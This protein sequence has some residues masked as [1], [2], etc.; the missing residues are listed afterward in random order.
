MGSPCAQSYYSRH[1]DSFNMDVNLLDL[2]VV[3]LAWNTFFPLIQSHQVE[4]MPDNTMTVFL[5]KQGTKSLPLFRSNQH[6]GLKSTF[7]QKSHNALYIS[8]KSTELSSNL[9]RHFPADQ[10]WEIHSSILNEIFTWWGIPSWV[11]I[12]N[13]QKSPPILLHGI[14]GS[15]LQG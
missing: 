9:S 7:Q 4:I 5:H 11:C 15:Q 2:G 8:I 10:E 13:E 6:L 1:L 14:S 3:S 12:P